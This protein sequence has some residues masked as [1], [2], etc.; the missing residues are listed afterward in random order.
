M[1]NEQASKEWLKV[2]LSGEGADEIFAGYSWHLNDIVRK[3]MKILNTL[4]IKLMLIHIF[5]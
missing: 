5:C 2:L 4:S 3:I 1:M